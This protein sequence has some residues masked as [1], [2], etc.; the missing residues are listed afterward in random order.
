LTLSNNYDPTRTTALRNAFARA[1]NRRF[2]EL[3]KVIKIAVVDQDCFG[4][5]KR[6]ITTQQMIPPG[7]HAFDY[8]RSSERIEVFMR[9]LRQQVDRGILTTTQFQQIGSAI[10]S[11]WTN[12]Y[13]ADSYKRGIIR[14]RNEMIAAG[15][16]IPSIDSSGGI[17][18]VFG[19]P[20]HMDR[21]GVLFTR[22]FAELVGVT[23]AM[24]NN[25]AQ[26]L[27]Q[28]MIDGDGPAL[29]ARK[30]IAAIDGTGAGTLGITDRLGRFIPA[31]RRA[32]MIA[33]TELIRAHHLATIQEYRN[34]GVLGIKVKG[35]WK[36]AG[37]DRV[38]ERCAE[39]EGKIFTLDEIEPMIPLH[40]MC[41][42]D[43]QIPIYTSTG[44]KPIGKIE[45]GDLV[46]THKR[47]FRKV[48]A[49][50]RHKG[51]EK[52]ITFK[53]KGDLVLSMTEN[54]PVLLTSKN[55]KFSRWVEAGKIKEGDSLRLLGNECKRC[56][57][58]I[59]FFRKYC[60]RTCLSKDITD[61]QWNDPK[62]RE[63]VSTKNS[64]S[65]FSQYSS[66]KR[67][68]YTITKKANER[69]R[70]LGKEGAYTKWMTPEFFEK[71]RKVTNT[72]DMKRQSSLRMKKKNPMYDPITVKKAQEAIQKHL[73]E[74]PEKRINARMAKYRKSGNKTWIEERMGLLLDKLGV[75]YV[76]QYPILRYNVDY[77]IPELMLVI[78]CDGEQWH[79]DKEK[80]QIRQ[81]RIEHEGWTV[82][83]YT[84]REINQ[85]LPEIEKELSRV[86]CNHLGE[87]EL[88]IWPVES[89]KKWEMT[90]MR[91]LY[92]LSV[93]ED[94]SY[95]AKGVI[96][97][98]CRC[99]ALPYIEH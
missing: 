62:H 35:E 37:D 15:M 58:P 9:W 92:N 80:E 78:E 91:T 17:N 8:T 56:K 49:L 81:E 51:K 87:F 48:Y 83:H 40:P 53:F 24:A 4:A 33:R 16:D 71:V 38:C 10:E 13:V 7:W 26:I 6:S 22:V 60:S 43:P 64:K 94:E 97:H 3:I 95:I 21:V 12:M 44:W 19:T 30:M 54:H 67:D 79:Q 23:E 29:L 93:E 84:G 76:F 42:I 50:P 77:A 98:N 75:D 52:V 18:V 1:M 2:D 68:R 96:V 45:I 55:G 72:P 47:R 86:L 99:I 31:K 46:L 70:Q 25:I 89:V 11:A 57:K 66:G 34:W 63:I 27:A 14:A 28:G 61:I 88:V 41:F 85:C 65:M 74:N 73:L 82:L 32:E 39:L 59:P 20:F 5:K 90:R 69:M 36:T